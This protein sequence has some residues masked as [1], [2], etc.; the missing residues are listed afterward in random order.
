MRAGKI[1][2]QSGRTE[3]VLTQLRAG[4]GKS[5]GMELT[6]SFRN[7]ENLVGARRFELLTPCAQGRAKRHGQVA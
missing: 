3:G 1:L 7:S 2:T 4:T 6:N 5:D